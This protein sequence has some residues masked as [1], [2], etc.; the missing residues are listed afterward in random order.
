MKLCYVTAN[1]FQNTHFYYEDGFG[2]ELKST[3]AWLR[4]LCKKKCQIRYEFFSFYA[5]NFKN[6]LINET[7]NQRTDEFVRFGVPLMSDKDSTYA[8][9]YFIQRGITVGIFEL[10]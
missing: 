3:L 4:S 8:M 6:D 5:I 9:P 1:I 2:A 7:A 10:I